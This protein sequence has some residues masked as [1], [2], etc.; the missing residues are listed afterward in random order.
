MTSHK[1]NFYDISRR[2]RRQRGI[3]KISTEQYSIRR[4]KIIKCLS[5]RTFRKTINMEFYGSIK[6]NKDR[7]AKQ[8]KRDGTWTKIRNNKKFST[9]NSLK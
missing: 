3:T 7:R 8:E 6:Y 1:G 4:K 5:K 9:S 2:Q